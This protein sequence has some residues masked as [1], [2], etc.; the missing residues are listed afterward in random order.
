MG[1]NPIAAGHNPIAAPHINIAAGHNP[2]AVPH[3]AN[4]LR[5][6]GIAAGQNPIAAPHIGIAADHNANGA[7][8]FERSEFAV[9]PSCLRR[10]N[11]PTKYRSLIRSHL[12]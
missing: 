9:R 1:H 3:N 12:S 2:I 5:N 11:P 7:I 10:D 8:L 4:V 6:N